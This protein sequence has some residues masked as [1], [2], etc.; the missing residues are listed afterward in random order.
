MYSD[1]VYTGWI[2]QKM[3]EKMKENVGK[4]SSFLF[5]SDST[6]PL[7][8]RKIE[9]WFR[10]TIKVVDLLL[11]NCK[12]SFAPQQNQRKETNL[13]FLPKSWYRLQA[14]FYCWRNCYWSPLCV[15]LSPIINHHGFKYTRKKRFARSFQERKTCSVLFF[16]VSWRM[17]FR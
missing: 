5:V 14:I 4:T 16:S 1:N 17:T 2:Q 15:A 7:T 8:N 6:L 3:K 13:L 10:K 11:L 12:L 9:K